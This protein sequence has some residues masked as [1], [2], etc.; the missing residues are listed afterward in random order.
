MSDLGCDRTFRKVHTREFLILSQVHRHPRIDEHS[1]AWFLALTRGVFDDL[2]HRELFVFIHAL[3][4]ALET[5]TLG[6]DVALLLHLRTHLLDVLEERL[7]TLELEHAKLLLT[8]LLDRVE[9]AAPLGL[10]PTRTHRAH[11]GTQVDLGC[12]LDASVFVG[13]MVDALFPAGALERQ[14]GRGRPRR[15]GIQK[16]G[17]LTELPNLGR[18][19]LL[20]M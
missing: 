20:G 13:A 16:P 15:P 12:E 1:P 2:N 5:P 7:S 14:V 9:E 8:N 17:L 19:T 11:L 4:P 18:A 6:G 10:D 3:D